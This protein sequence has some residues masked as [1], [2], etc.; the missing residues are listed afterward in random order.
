[1]IIMTYVLSD[2][3][4]KPKDEEVKPVKEPDLKPQKDTGCVL[5]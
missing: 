5:S 2:L 3:Q 1:M 4:A